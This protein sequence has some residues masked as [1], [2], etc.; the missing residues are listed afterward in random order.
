VCRC[1]TRYRLEEGDEV[2]LMLEKRY[3]PLHIGPGFV[4]KASTCVA[5][6]P[7]DELE[8]VFRLFR[9]RPEIVN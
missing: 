1:G 6:A 9:A 2:L 5:C 7:G 8:A 3:R 4:V